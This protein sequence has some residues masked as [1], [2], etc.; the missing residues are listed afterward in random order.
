MSEFVPYLILDRA[1]LG[2]YTCLEVLPARL[3]DGS[4]LKID[5]F[6]IEYWAIEF[7]RLSDEQKAAIFACMDQAKKVTE[8]SGQSIFVLKIDLGPV[9]C[10]W[11]GYGIL[12]ACVKFLILN[13]EMEKRFCK[14]FGINY[15]TLPPF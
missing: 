1:R 6:G 3:I 12:R 15:E 11:M 8:C 14:Q 2:R 9:C 7:G 10:T 5:L 13:E 4:L